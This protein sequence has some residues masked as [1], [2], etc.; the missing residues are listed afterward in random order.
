[1]IK[2]Q[3]MPSDVNNEEILEALQLVAREKFV[4]DN[5]KSVC[6]YDGSIPLSATRHIL[7]PEIFAKML[8]SSGINSNSRVLDVAC[9]TGYSSSVISKMAKEVVG[10][11]SEQNLAFEA[12]KNLSGSNNIFIKHG[13]ILTGASES[14]P[15]DVI[16][17]N[18]AISAE[19]NKLIDQLADKGRLIYVKT[20]LDGTKK[21]AL[22]TKNSISYDVLELFSCNAPNLF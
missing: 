19:P 16:F 5:W 4:P 7:P 6:Y 13:E 21:V 20:A 9:G 8:K 3:I 10:L 17:I 15:F 22:I 1:M 11:E 18:G 12:A 14:A 2:N